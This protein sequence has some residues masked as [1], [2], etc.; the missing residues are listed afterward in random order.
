MNEEIVKHLAGLDEKTRAT[1]ID[2]I[3]TIPID[4]K[5]KELIRFEHITTT[6]TV[7]AS[8]VDI[9]NSAS[10]YTTNVRNKKLIG[11]AL[12]LSDEAQLPNSTIELYCDGL[13][14][15]SS[16]TPAKTIF[17]STQVGNNA[18]IFELLSR[19]IKQSRITGRYTDGNVGGVPYTVK[20]TLMV[21]A[22][23]PY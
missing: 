20:L 14:I 2:F 7:A 18:K 8:T 15:F 5:Q 9:N 11:I 16:G 3:N 10:G 21:L 23:E 4:S 6:I 17:M 12:T 13:E 22:I 1:I 19:K